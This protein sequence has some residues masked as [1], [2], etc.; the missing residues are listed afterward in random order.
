MYDTNIEYIYKMYK[1]YGWPIKKRLY[2]IHF[3]IIFNTTFDS[4]TLDGL[5]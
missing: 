3:I 5:T 4:L 2:L 1:L